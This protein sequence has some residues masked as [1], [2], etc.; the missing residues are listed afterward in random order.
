MR[1]VIRTA[2]AVI[3]TLGV[4]ATVLGV[5]S[6]LAPSLP[7]SAANGFGPGNGPQGAGQHWGGAYTLQNVAGYAYCIQPGAAG[8]D[9]IPN[10]QYS[11]VPYPGA[12]G[13][14]TDG[15]M[16][17]LAYFAEEYQGSG[18]SCRD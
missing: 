14:Y 11:P 9:Q 16:A 3:T 7:A 17:A 1:R 15:E 6:A 2:A 4:S 10:D 13:G 18:D 8:P 5:S 12:G